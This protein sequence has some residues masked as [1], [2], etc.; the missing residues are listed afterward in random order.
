[1]DADGDALTPYRAKRSAAHTPEPVPGAGP[2][3]RGRDDTFVIQE[4]HARRLHWDFRLERGGVLVSWALPKGLPDDPRRNHLAVQTE[5]HP[6]EYAAFGGQIPAGQYGGGSV[7]IW[8]RGTYDCEKWTDDEVKVVLHGTRS[9]GRFALIHTDN[10]NWLIHLMKA[11]STEP[12]P[13]TADGLVPP[14]LAT[15]ASLPADDAAYGFEVKWDGLRAVAYVHDGALR[16]M[17][18]NGVD[19]T[20]VYPELQ[21]LADALGGVNAVFDGE[22]VAVDAAGRV[23][24]GALQPRMHLRDARQIER[25]AAQRPVA[26]RIF[27]LLRL[28]GHDTTSLAYTQRRELLDGLRLHGPRWQTPPYTRGGGAERLAAAVRDGMEGIMAKSLDSPY[29]PGRRSP[30]WLKIKNVHTQ[31]VVIGGWRP[32]NGNRAGTI[33]SLLLGIPGADGL[34]YVGHVGTGFTRDMLDHL[35]R[36]LTASARMTSPFVD[37]LPTREAKDAQWVTPKLVGEVAFTEWTRDGRLRQPAWRGL[38]PDK[39]PDQ[40]VREP[41]QTRQREVTGRATPGLERR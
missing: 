30:T 17:N 19:I 3:P 26:Y 34:T 40:V 10:R 35:H 16:L 8:D 29:L 37:T 32:G 9:N 14:M 15:A 36:T 2:L 20:S 39:T 21:P 18:R 1:M 28:D 24:F 5:D 41:L 27:D 38:R 11:E 7:E 23:S 4:H 12:P 31:E 33:G 22:I 13:P 6:L 25:L